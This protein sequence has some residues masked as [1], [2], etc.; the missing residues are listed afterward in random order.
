MD[1][2]EGRVCVWV[3]KERKSKLFIAVSKTRTNFF[4]ISAYKC[5]VTNRGINAVDVRN[6]SKR[7]S[8]FVPLEGR[9]IL[10]FR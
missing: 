6:N 5:F 10:K 9:V 3:E 7:V 2:M 4:D 1:F 8:R